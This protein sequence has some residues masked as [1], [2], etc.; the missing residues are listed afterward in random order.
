LKSAVLFYLIAG[1]VALSERVSG[2]EHPSLGPPPGVV[3]AR[4][5]DAAKAFLFS[6][7]L[8]IL[9]N[10]HYAAS[11]EGYGLTHVE[12][13]TDRGVTWQPQAKVSDLKW[14]TLFVHRAALYLIGVSRKSGSMVIRRSNDLGTTWTTPKDQGSGLLGAGR[15]HCAPVPVVVHDGR[16]WRAFEEFAAPPDRPVRHFGAFMMSA[17]EDANLLDGAV[18]TRSNKIAFNREWIQARSKEWLEGNAVVTPT[19]DLV[20]ILRVGSHP[21]GGHP[22][23]F[24]TVRPGI[25]RFEVAAKMRLSA[26]GKTATFDP[27]RDF[28]PMIG[29]EAKFTIRYDPTSKRYWTLANKITHPTSGAD[30]PHSPHHQRNVVALTSSSDLKSWSEHYRGLSYAAGTGVVKN[31]SRVGFQYLD[32][33]FDGDDLVAVCRT[34]WDGANYHD[35]NCIT[36]HRI[37]SFRSLTLADSPPDLAVRRPKATK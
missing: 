28:I 19:G 34:S 10:G 36:F 18:W 8:A 15:F 12:R 6:P 13:S 29:G 25:P 16:V 30:W 26:D 17:P 1:L 31:G 2:K 22:D 37:P 35:S 32:W 11:Y 21:A 23:P 7:S 9:P 27:D 14:A 5:S 20:N 33:Q 4:S 3:I 24:A